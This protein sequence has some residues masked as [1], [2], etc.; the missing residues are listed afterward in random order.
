MPI[1]D[2]D[3]E[4][5]KQVADYFESTRKPDDQNAK[6]K[7]KREDSRSINDTAA[8]FN[9]TR[10]KVTK[11]LVTMGVYDSPLSQQVQE[12]RSQG[13]GV[14]EIA[15]TLGVST[16]TVSSYIPYEDEIH[17]SDDASDHAKCMREYRAYERMQKERQVQERKGQ[18]VATDSRDDW[19]KDLDSKLSF[20]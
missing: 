4:L 2:K 5:M 9:L 16:G 17:G 12:L 3:R 20:T 6:Y 13:M 18:D 19:K 1:S 11:M 8:H 10:T 15:E 14:K 7:A